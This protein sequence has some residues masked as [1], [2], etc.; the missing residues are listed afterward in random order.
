MLPLGIDMACL[1]ASFV[2]RTAQA[3]SCST[4]S[5]QRMSSVLGG[6]S[7]RFRTLGG[8]GTCRHGVLAELEASET[9]STT[10]RLR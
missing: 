2:P 3:W 8:P 1:K 7:D 9:L 6:P 4:N 5:S 10:G